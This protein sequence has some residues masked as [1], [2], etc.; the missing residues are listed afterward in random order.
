M[1]VVPPD[2]CGQGSRGG[3]RVDPTPWKGE[4]MTPLQ[5]LGPPSGPPGFSQLSSARVPLTCIEPCIFSPSF[6]RSRNSPPSVMR[7]GAP[8]KKVG[9]STCSPSGPAMKT[10]LTP[11][12]VSR[13]R[14]PSE[15]ERARS[16]ARTVIFSFTWSERREI[17]PDRSCLQ[18]LKGNCEAGPER[19]PFRCL[20][21]WSS[22]CVN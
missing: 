5:K 10:C 14:K 6:L 18:H 1:K 19:G 3:G 7:N 4:A 8:R 12:E 21:C 16:N 17:W 9:A 20:I 22:R 2:G 13:S 15:G 11:N